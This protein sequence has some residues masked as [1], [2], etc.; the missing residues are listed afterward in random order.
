MRAS[1]VY[2]AVMLSSRVSGNCSCRNSIANPS[3]M[4]RTTRPCTLPSVS[5]ERIGGRSDALQGR[6]RAGEEFEARGRQGDDADAADEQW[7]AEMRLQ[8]FHLTADRA[9]GHAQLRGRE[10]EA[11]MPGSGDEGP[12]RIEGRHARGHV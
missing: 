2:R 12:N 8:V 10:G 9:V 5:C 1:T 4:W 6:F 11:S 7:H 3:S